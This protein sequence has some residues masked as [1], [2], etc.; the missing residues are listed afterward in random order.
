MTPFSSVAMIEKLA[1]LKIACWSAPVL[2]RAASRRT[3]FT[4]EL[5]SSPQFDKGEVGGSTITYST[6]YTRGW[7][8]ILAHRF[9]SAGAPVPGK[10]EIN[11]GLEVLPEQRVR[12]L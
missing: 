2:R 7:F 3:S 4:C 9:L 11:Q 10:F 6:I 1:L 12:Q 5:G 8:F